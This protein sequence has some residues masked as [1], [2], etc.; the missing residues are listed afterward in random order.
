MN[1]FDYRR[2]ILII[3]RIRT[4]KYGVSAVFRVLQ[5]VYE[6]DKFSELRNSLRSPEFGTPARYARRS[7]ELRRA[8]LAGARFARSSDARARYARHSSLRSQCQQTQCSLRSLRSPNTNFCHRITGY[9][10]PIA[11]SAVQITSVRVLYSSRSPVSTLE[12]SQS[13][14]L[15][16]TIALHHRRVRYSSLS[17]HEQVNAARFIM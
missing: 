10:V 1:I 9:R 13:P 16:T 11:V 8:T 7:S 2:R 4:K 14:R 12:S 5:V 3:S 15:P 17:V 6:F